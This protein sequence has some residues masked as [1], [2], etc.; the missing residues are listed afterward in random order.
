MLPEP[1]GRHVF[2]PEYAVRGSTAAWN[3]ITSEA[4]DRSAG[5]GGAALNDVLT[6]K[7]SGDYLKDAINGSFRAQVGLLLV[8]TPADDKHGTSEL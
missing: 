8:S 6:G 5:A 2:V 7:D 3:T 1:T 4:I